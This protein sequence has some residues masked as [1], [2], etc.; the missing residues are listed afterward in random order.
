MADERSLWDLL[1]ELV[2]QRQNIMVDNDGVIERLG[3]LDELAAAKH[4]KRIIVQWG[5]RKRGGRPAP[6]PGQ[7]SMP[8]GIEA[9]AAASVA[10]DGETQSVTADG[11]PPAPDSEPGDDPPSGQ[12]EE[13]A[14]AEV[15]S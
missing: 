1:A 4:V 14:S 3:E 5:N 13:P 6:L 11:E 7:T 9:E 2:K 8:L 10:L 15:E 12:P